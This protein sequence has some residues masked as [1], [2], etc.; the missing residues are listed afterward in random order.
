VTAISPDVIDVLRGC[1]TNGNVLVIGGQLDRKQYEAVNK[2]L[3]AAGGKWNRQQRGHVFDDPAGPVLAAM[4]ETGQV[5]GWRDEGWFPTPP[6]V[7]E[8]L[9]DLAD[10]ESGMDVLEPS[11]GEGAIAVHVTAAGCLVDC[12]E[13]NP[14]RASRLRDAGYARRIGQMDFL[15]FRGWGDR[16]DRVIMNPPFGNDADLRHVLHADTFLKPGGRLVSVM[17]AG[18]EFQQ[19]RKWPAFRA[20]VEGRGGWLTR[21]PDESFKEVGTAVRTVVAMI[22]A[23][24]R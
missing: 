2:I 13:L 3:D 4:I 18:A 11:A 9:L 21:L 20:L 5:T 12:I 6:D 8:M 1:T 19:D 7:V 24:Y 16:Y 23:R 15:E 22:P 17:A 10:L 14:R